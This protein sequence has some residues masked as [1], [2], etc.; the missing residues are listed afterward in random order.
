MMKDCF[1]N[2]EHHL[3]WSWLL[4]SWGRPEL[5]FFSISFN[6]VSSSIAQIMDQK[7][8]ISLLNL[9][10]ILFCV[11]ICHICNLYS[12]QDTKNALQKRTGSTIISDSTLA[13]SPLA[14]S[15][16]PDPY[17]R[18]PYTS[19]GNNQLSLTTLTFLCNGNNLVV[20]V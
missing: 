19:H 9:P 13:R 18:G 15:Y 4:L 17:Q 8:Q 16:Q 5:K 7:L 11:N 1:V 20:V 2:L 14:R 3:P 6:I 10:L 12:L